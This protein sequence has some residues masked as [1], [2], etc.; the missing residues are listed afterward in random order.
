MDVLVLNVAIDW[1]WC[2]VTI[3][4]FS[5]LIVVSFV[6]LVDERE[7]HHKNDIEKSTIQL[8]LSIMHSK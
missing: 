7:L 6:L 2:G 4:L 3:F 8:E 5:L 1:M